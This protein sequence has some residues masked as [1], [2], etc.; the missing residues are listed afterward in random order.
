MCSEILLKIHRYVC[1]VKGDDGKSRQTTWCCRMF[2]IITFDYGLRYVSVI[3]F[4]FK[5]KNKLQ[6]SNGSIYFVRYEMKSSLSIVKLP[7]GLT[8]SYYS[9][10]KNKIK[11]VCGDTLRATSVTLAGSW[12]RRWLVVKRLKSEENKNK[13]KVK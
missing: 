11:I 3:I 4:L 1:V 10:I 13:I 8:V 6:N 12:R 2:V 7:I 9:S 5:K